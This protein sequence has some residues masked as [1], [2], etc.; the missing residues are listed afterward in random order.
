MQISIYYRSN[1]CGHM[2]ISYPGTAQIFIQNT[3]CKSAVHSID[4]MQYRGCYAISSHPAAKMSMDGL[5]GASCATCISPP[6]S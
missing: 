4:F 5:K 3:L 1:S 6:C 2:Y